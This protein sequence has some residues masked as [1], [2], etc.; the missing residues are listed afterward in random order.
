M[1]ETQLNEM[2]LILKRLQRGGE[3]GVQMAWVGN[4]VEWGGSG[5]ETCRTGR[6][7]QG[8]NWQKIWDTEARQGSSVEALRGRELETRFHFVHFYTEATRVSYSVKCCE[9]MLWCSAR[10]GTRARWPG[11]PHP[12]THRP[13]SRPTPH[14]RMLTMGC[15]CSTLRSMGSTRLSMSFSRIRYMS[16]PWDTMRKHA[17]FLMQ[18]GK[19]NCMWK[20]PG[21]LCQPSKEVTLRSVICLPKKF[22]FW[23]RIVISFRFLSYAQFLSP[24]L[25]PLKCVLTLLSRMLLNLIIYTSESLWQKANGGFPGEFSLSLILCPSN[26]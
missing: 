18:A 1:A 8:Q 3:K 4:L 16:F 11:L 7:D 10:T 5:G 12:G 23:T 9:T 20:H 17:V 13:L 15:E 21:T 22:P 24:S 25:S 2:E 19:P 6:Q 14:T 26:S